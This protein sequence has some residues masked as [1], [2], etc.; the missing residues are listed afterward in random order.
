MNRILICPYLR[1]P[2]QSHLELLLDK[3]FQKKWFDPNYKHAFSDSLYYYVFELL[4]D[5]I[6]SDK[7]DEEIGRIFYNKEEADTIA[8]F[9]NLIIKKQNS[10][11]FL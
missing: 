9:L 1:E 2:I 10:L 8:K 4:F 7:S 3:E 5:S 6:D 11:F